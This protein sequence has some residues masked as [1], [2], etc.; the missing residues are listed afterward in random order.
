MTQVLSQNQ[1]IQQVASLIRLLRAPTSPSVQNLAK[2][3]LIDLL[4][5]MRSSDASLLGVLER[6][7]LLRYLAISPCDSAY[8]EV[9]EL[10]SSS[11]F[12][13]EID[14]RLSI[15]SALQQVGGSIR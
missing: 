7:V 4:P 15:L 8:R 14:L 12:R 1:D 5:K 13:R 6:N 9:V 3:A 11:A 2:R 10:F